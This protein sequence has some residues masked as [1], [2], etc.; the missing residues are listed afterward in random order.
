M[1]VK[2][3]LNAYADKYK[4]LVTPKPFVPPA[5]WNP[6]QEDLNDLQ[7][8][9]ERW[10]ETSKWTGAGVL[11][12]GGGAIAVAIATAAGV[13]PGFVASAAIGLFVAGT[14]AQQVLHYRED[15]LRLEIDATRA[16][17]RRKGRAIN[18]EN[19]ARQVKLAIAGVKSPFKKSATPEAAPAAD[20]APAPKPPRRK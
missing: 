1:N 7:A 11:V 19:I 17:C 9:Y 2:S 16:V 3:L 8:R 13:V 12:L 14:A 20:A 10:Q 5:G 6:V 15:K 18:A 4:A